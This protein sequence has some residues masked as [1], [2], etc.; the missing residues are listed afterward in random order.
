M[1]Q[2]NIKARITMIKFIKENAGVN[3]YNL[4][5]GHYFLDM[6]LKTGATSEN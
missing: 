1:E 4:E 3:L 5:W 2:T 6:T